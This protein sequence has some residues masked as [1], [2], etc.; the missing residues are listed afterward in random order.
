MNPQE[1]RTFLNRSWKALAGLF[2]LE[3]AWGTWD[4]AQPT[5]A[6]AFGGV[7][8]AGDR[9][10]FPEGTVRYFPNGR[11]YVAAHEGELQALY[12]KC[13]HLGCRVPFCE[14]SKRFECPCHGSVYNIKGERLEGPAPRGLDRFPLR[15]EGDQ[16]LVDTGTIIEGPPEGVVTGPHSARGPACNG[17][18]PP[19]PTPSAST[20][21]SEE[22][23]G[24]EVR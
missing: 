15:V 13:P 1:R 4:M 11:F 14:T 24:G 23:G 16:V 21:G 7:V 6:G 2:V 22:S 9:S 18:F 8:K 19:L 5:Q 10:E 17:V 12:Q 20:A 3:A